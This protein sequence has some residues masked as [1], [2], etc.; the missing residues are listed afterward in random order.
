MLR[1]QGPAEDIE[2]FSVL[3]GLFL[4]LFL[5][6]LRCD[7]RMMDR[8]FEKLKQQLLLREEEEAS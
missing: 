8:G 6:A 5:A 3:G 4:T 2:G 1:R 7:F